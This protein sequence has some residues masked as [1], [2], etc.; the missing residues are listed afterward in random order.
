MTRTHIWIC[1][2]TLARQGLSSRVTVAAIGPSLVSRNREARLDP[3]ASGPSLGYASRPEGLHPETRRDVNP[4]RD[5][6]ANIRENDE[7]TTRSVRRA[8]SRAH[9]RVTRP[10]EGPLRAGR[11]GHICWLGDRAQG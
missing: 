3:L 5:H 8:R 6:R 11:R 4:H 9:D 1:T 10:L 7:N 2:T